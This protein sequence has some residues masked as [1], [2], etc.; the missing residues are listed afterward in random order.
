MYSEGSG[1]R[2]RMNRPRRKILGGFM[3][4]RME[5]INKK[6]D[7]RMFQDGRV[8]FGGEQ[9]GGAQSGGAQSGGIRHRPRFRGTIYGGCG[10]CKGICGGASN[11]MELVTALMRHVEGG[12]I[13]G[14]E[15]A[16]VMMDYSPS[17]DMNGSG[18]F[19]DLVATIG[20]ALPFLA[21][22]LNAV[23][24]V[25]PLLSLGAS[26]LGSVARVGSEAI[27]KIGGKKRAKSMKTKSRKTKSR[28][29]KAKP[30]K[31]RAKPRKSNNCNNKMSTR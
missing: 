31:T 23:P 3:N 29:T 2:K 5:M 1:G 28:K 17:S 22:V 21:P 24:V 8:F 27:K 9:S 12:S 10:E 14:G 30:R 6:Y 13:S 16:E 4:P 25:G 15:I 7:N 18:F 11:P 26:Q 20:N 19:G